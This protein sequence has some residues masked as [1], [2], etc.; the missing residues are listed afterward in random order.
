[1]PAFALIT[2]VMTLG[3]VPLAMWWAGAEKQYVAVW[4]GT[5]IVVA[6]S[7]GI[8]GAIWS[9]PDSPLYYLEIDADAVIYRS[10]ITMMRL[11]WPT[12][13]RFTVYA[14]GDRPEFFLRVTRSSGLPV[15]DFALNVS[16]FVA[17][18]D[19]HSA[20]RLADWLN[21]LRTRAVEHPERA[22]EDTT[23]PQGFRGIPVVR[24]SLV[25]SEPLRSGAIER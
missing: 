20:G 11:R 9:R 12:I 22:G 6:L 19:A 15:L 5:L 1:M 21:A 3:V 23:V 14:I 13:Q 18:A 24:T 25:R 4:T 16:D 7:T 10:G 17:D 2:G 8:G